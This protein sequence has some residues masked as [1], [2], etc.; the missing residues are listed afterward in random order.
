MIRFRWI[1]PHY[2]IVFLVGILLCTPLLAETLYGR[3]VGV[4]DGDTVDILV[5]Q[6]PIRIRLGEIDTP[7]RDQPYGSR[8]KQALSTKVFNKTI[9]VN[10]DTT[11][12]YG[13][14]VGH[15]TLDGRDINREMVAEGHAWVYR[16]YLDDVSLLQNEEEARVMRLGLWALPEAQNQAPW[17]WREF[18]RTSP[19]KPPQQ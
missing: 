9:T 10:V 2:Y 5:D 1:S 19:A 8:A 15:L 14:K 7:E 3:V 13:R 6:Q 17:E 16:K 12:R 4:I 11:D 18:K